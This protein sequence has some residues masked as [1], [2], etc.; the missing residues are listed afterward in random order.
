M[1]KRKAA[2]DDL[3]GLKEG[4][5][6]HTSNNLG[7]SAELG[8]KNDDFEM[9]SSSSWQMKLYFPFTKIRESTVYVI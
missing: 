8:W 3:P 1:P 4:P 9:V 6:F 2:P 7:F 5:H